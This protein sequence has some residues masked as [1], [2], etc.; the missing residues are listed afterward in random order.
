MSCYR[1]ICTEAAWRSSPLCTDQRP[2]PLYNPSGFINNKI[3]ILTG[4]TLYNGVVHDDQGQRTAVVDEQWMVLGYEDQTLFGN[5][6]HCTAWRS[7]PNSTVPC[8]KVRYSTAQYRPDSTPA[9]H[10]PETTDR[11]AVHLLYSPW[12]IPAVHPALHCL[13]LP[14]T[15]SIRTVWWFRFNS[16][17]KACPRPTKEDSLTLPYTVVDR[18]TVVAFLIIYASLDRSG[19]KAPFPHGYPW[20]TTD[21]ST[22]YTV[23]YRVTVGPF[24]MLPCKNPV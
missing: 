22:W 4:P 1:S 5:A 10:C 3:Y 7:T 23:G 6:V 21:C 15:E 24:L 12:Y 8:R 2:S 14:W 16:G 17:Q 11:P 18:Y 13:V 9:V 20:Y 19:R